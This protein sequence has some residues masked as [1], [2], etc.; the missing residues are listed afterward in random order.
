M[1]YDYYEE[2]RRQEQARIYQDKN[3][4]I[5]RK[6]NEY[7]AYVSGNMDVDSSR[8][9]KS[10]NPELVEIIEARKREKARKESNIPSILRGDDDIKA[11]YDKLTLFKSD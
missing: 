4:F 8:R 11:F 3:G 9:F 1:T 6:H 7:S 10:N 2:R 5:L